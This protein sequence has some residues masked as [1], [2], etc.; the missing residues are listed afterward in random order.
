MAIEFTRIP[1]ASWAFI[2]CGLTAE[3]ARIQGTL[4]VEI[5]KYK[6]EGPNRDDQLVYAWFGPQ[7]ASVLSVHWY[8]VCIGTQCETALRPQVHLADLYLQPSPV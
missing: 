7:C 2:L 6:L 8:S 1:C 3:P 5:G 4:G